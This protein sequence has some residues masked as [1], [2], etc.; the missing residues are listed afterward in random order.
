MH[1]KQFLSILGL[2]LMCAI[3]AKG[4]YA[5]LKKVQVN[6]DIQL[7]LPE[8]FTA[9]SEQ[10]IQAKYISYRSPI[11]LYT[12]PSRTV[13]LGINLSVTHWEPHD[14]ALLQEFYENSIRT[15]YTQVEFLKKDIETVNDIRYAVFE[16][17]STVTDE[18]SIVN[19]TQAISKYTL[20]YYAIVNNKTI[21]FNFTCPAKDREIWQDTAQEIMNSIKI[22]KTL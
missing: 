18:E 13:D 1:S 19:R 15:L 9:M 16:F 2:L 14:L 8:D 5:E 6:K 11:A 21:L 22:K 3:S 7:S 4:Q 17:V 12:N 10:D 20:I